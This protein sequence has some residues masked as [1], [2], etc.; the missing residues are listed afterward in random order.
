[1]A[2]GT[3]RAKRGQEINTSFGSKNLHPSPITSY[4]MPHFFRF[5]H[6]SVLGKGYH[7]I[8]ITVKEEQKWVYFILEKMSCTSLSCTPQH[9]SSHLQL[10]LTG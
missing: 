10:L 9:P 8:S 1:M 7:F 2:S 6:A 4:V 3:C 5:H